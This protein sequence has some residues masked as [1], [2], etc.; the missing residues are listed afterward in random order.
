[1]CI[2]GLSASNA[3]KEFLADVILSVAAWE[4]S[5]SMVM[6]LLGGQRRSS[7]SDLAAAVGSHELVL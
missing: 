1:M 2:D 7:A 6:W 4:L 5:G 3:W